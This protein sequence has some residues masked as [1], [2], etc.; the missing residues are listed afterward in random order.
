VACRETKTKA[1]FLVALNPI[2]VL[3]RYTQSSCVPKREA[4]S[5]SPSQ[6]KAGPETLGLF[7]REMNGKG[8]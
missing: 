7:K 3:P 4:D 5:F 2:Q 8:R 1:Q 6:I